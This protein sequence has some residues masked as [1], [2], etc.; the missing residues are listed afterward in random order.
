LPIAG[1]MCDEKAEVVEDKLG[2][3]K[4]EAIHLGVSKG[5]DTLIIFRKK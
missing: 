1:L 5:I 3:M 2:A 4:K